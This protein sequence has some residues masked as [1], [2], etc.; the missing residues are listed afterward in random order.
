MTWLG[1]KTPRDHKKKVSSSTSIPPSLRR[2]HLHTLARCLLS[3][4][5]SLVL[6]GSKDLFQKTYSLCY[7]A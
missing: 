7:P 3:P 1:Q 5:S 6:P 2:T 4:C